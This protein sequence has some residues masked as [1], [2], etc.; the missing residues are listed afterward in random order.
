MIKTR[1][2]VSVVWVC[3]TIRG[4]FFASVFP[5]WEG[6]DEYAHFAVIQYFSAHSGRLPD[7]ES[8]NTSAHVAESLRLTPVSPVITSFAPNLTDYDTYWRLP[9]A[10]RTHRAAQL[11]ALPREL[12][13][14]DAT[15]RLGL[16]EAQQAPLYYWLMSPV[17]RLTRG[18]SLLTQVWILR[19]CS[20][21]IASLAIPIAYLWFKRI[22]PGRSQMYAALGLLALFP[23]MTFSIYRIGNE[24]LAIAAG[25]ILLYAATRV[26]D[27]TPSLGEGLRFGVAFGLALLT[28][29]YFLALAPLAILVLAAPIFLNARPGVTKG[30]AAW[31]QAFAAIGSSVAV[32]SWWYIANVQ[33]G[34]SITGEQVAS[35]AGISALQAMANTPWPAAISFV[36]NSYIYLGNWSF[37]DVRSWM[38]TLV[39][40]AFFAGGAGVLWQMIRPASDAPARRHILAAALPCVT[41]VAAV[42]YTAAINYAT[43]SHGFTF[44]YYLYGL[45]PTQAALLAI[46]LTRWSARTIR[47]AP[48]AL[49]SLIFFA[50]ETYGTWFRML[51][52]YAGLVSHDVTGRMPALHIGQLS[53]G[54]LAKLFL[55]LAANKPPFLTPEA[56]ISLAG[57]YFAATGVLLAMILRLPWIRSI[58]QEQQPPV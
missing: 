3:F 24:C 22:F 42:C 21:L 53:E 45:A 5:L 51:P 7:P 49:L 54:G 4:V 47:F 56:L 43:P 26:L 30:N 57:L 39:K 36:T 18:C 27:A 10:E 19:F 52:Y 1:I 8:A 14:V 6:F 9:E 25:S 32:A 2:F 23:G 16:Y 29:A 12:E 41:F 20:V 28:K 15:P 38:Y 13:A 58:P 44:G 34:R 31:M 48:V 37:L 35:G 50:I 11:K 40:A 17:Y 46:G 33:A 55:N